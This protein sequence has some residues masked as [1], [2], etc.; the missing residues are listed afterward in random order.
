MRRSL[1]TATAAL[2]CALALG[3]T[4]SCSSLPYGI[5]GNLTDD[6]LPPP[7]CRANGA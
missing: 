1:G 7:R 3:A 4:A 6:W 2:L 5:D